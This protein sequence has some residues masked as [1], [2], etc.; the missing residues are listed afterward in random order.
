MKTQTARCRPVSIDATCCS[1]TEWNN[2]KVHGK[3][4][5][6]EKQISGHLDKSVNKTNFGPDN[7]SLQNYRF[8]ALPFTCSNHSLLDRHRCCRHHCRHH[9][10]GLVDMLCTEDRQNC[11]G[12][13]TISL[14]FFWQIWRKRIHARTNQR[15]YSFFFCLLYFIFLKLVFR[16]W[17]NGYM[18]LSITVFF[19]Q[20]Y[21]NLNTKFV[22]PI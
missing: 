10:S 14:R 11:R 6:V 19:K 4:N 5:A 17:S 1:E 15:F 20:S 8:I 2:S 18:K 22:W 12:S 13:S 9:S 3:F 7:N 16:N 21:K